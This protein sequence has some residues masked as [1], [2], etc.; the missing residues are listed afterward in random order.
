MRDRFV[1]ELR[2]S[3]KTEDNAQI[4]CSE[5][6][7][8]MIF[9]VNHVKSKRYEAETIGD[10]DSDDASRDD[11]W[12]ADDIK[13]NIDQLET[14]IIAADIEEEHLKQETDN[15]NAIEDESDYVEVQD[16]VYDQSENER[17]DTEN[18]EYYE[19]VQQIEYEEEVPEPS[20]ELHEMITDY[21]ASDNIIAV[22]EIPKEQ[23]FKR[24]SSSERSAV[25]KKRKLSFVIEEEPPTK[26]QSLSPDTS[27]DTLRNRTSE[28]NDEDTA[29]GNTIGLMLKKIPNHLKTLIKVKIMQSV[30]EF[31]A[32]YKLC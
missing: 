1:R 4:H 20:E 30:A 31:E 14:C 26:Q 8:D 5:F 16:D 29:F 7:R 6:F 27:L 9:L 21:D 11:V 23:W 17:N 15:L 18:E 32:Q 10:V 2:R 3:R 24:E 19:D 12:Q 13:P 25:I 22:Q 28:V